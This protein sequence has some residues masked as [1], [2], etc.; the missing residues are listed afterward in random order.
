MGKRERQRAREREHE[1]D[2][3]WDCRAYDD[4][5]NDVLTPENTYVL[6]Q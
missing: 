1:R 4:D 5:D 6:G 2:V 3:C